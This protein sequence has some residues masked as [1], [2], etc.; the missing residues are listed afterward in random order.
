MKPLAGIRVLDFTRVLAGPLCTAI[1]G[2]FGAD[3][4]KIESPKNGDE[5]REWGPPFIDG[6]SAYYLC[7]NRN[8]RSLTLNLKSEEGIKIL[9]KLALISDVIT[10]NFTPTRIANLNLSYERF[11]S[12]N[13]RIIWANISGFGL[14]GPRKEEPGYD[15]MIQGFSGL[16]S[17]TGGESDEPIKVGV[18][19]ADVITALYTANSIITA[20][21]RRE[22]TGKGAKIDNSLLECAT[23]SLVNVASGYLIS[24]KLPKRYGN[25]HPNIVPYQVFK[26]FDGYFILAVGNDNQWIKLCKIIAR[27]NLVNDERFLTNAKRVENRE[28]LIPILN[29]EFKK[30]EMNYWLNKLKEY[31]IPAGPVNTIDKTL[32]DPQ[33]IDRG[34]IESVTHPKCGEI[35]LLRNPIHFHDVDLNIIRHPPLLGEHTS[36]ILKELSYSDP[37]IE[38]LKAKGVISSL[39]KGNLNP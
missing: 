2:D 26:A 24:G 1:L 39:E 12:I 10:L 14:T 32:I 6:E 33:I 19:I 13:E 31:N 27:E 34:L 18:A 23:S 15:I 20:L 11:K 30:K 8:K 3:I 7:A 28:I 4:I 21:Y 25:A 5:T 38:E 37:E 17:I 22:K 36:K 9:D 35:K 16:M 29:E